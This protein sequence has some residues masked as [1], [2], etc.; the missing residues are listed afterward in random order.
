MMGFAIEVIFFS[1]LIFLLTALAIRGTIHVIEWAFPQPHRILCPCSPCYE[2]RMKEAV[3]DAEWEKQ[4]KLI[5]DAVKEV[6]RR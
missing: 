1:T 4:Q 6:T 5:Q 3:E 2:Q